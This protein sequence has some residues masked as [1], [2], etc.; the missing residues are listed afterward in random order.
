M[1]GYEVTRLSWRVCTDWAK[2]RPLT[3]RLADYLGRGRGR[4][5]LFDGLNLPKR[6]PL[7]PD[8][9]NWESLDLAAA[10]IG[11]ATILLRIGGM[12]VLT[13]PVLSHRVGL[14]MGLITMGPKRLV[15]PALKLNQLPKLDLILISH[16]HFDHL[17]V[18]T[19]HRLPKDVPV[20]TAH[21]TQD[22]FRGLGFST[23]S[24][25]Q[26]TLR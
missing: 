15:A 23:V 20:V 10:W 7:S 13:D 8:L 4:L 18:P 24:E 21:R 2:Y 12:T 22:L 6:A 16:A 11:H 17:D 14:G 1:L 9:S 5:R 26:S 19:L 25:M 3:L